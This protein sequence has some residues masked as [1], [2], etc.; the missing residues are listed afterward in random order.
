MHQVSNTLAMRFKIFDTVGHTWIDQ[1]YI[2]G[3]TGELLSLRLSSSSCTEF[4]LQ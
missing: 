2:I 4:E 3:N 1:V